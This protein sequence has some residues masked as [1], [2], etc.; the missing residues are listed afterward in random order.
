M[1]CVKAFGVGSVG[2]C[3]ITLAFTVVTVDVCPASW[4]CEVRRAAALRSPPEPVFTDEELVFQSPY[5]PTAET[6][7]RS[8]AGS[9]SCKPGVHEE[10]VQG[11]PKT[12]KKSLQAS[13]S[14]RDPAPSRLELSIDRSLEAAEERYLASSQPTLLVPDMEIPRV[15][16]VRGPGL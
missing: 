5:D 6:M 1:G 9:W 13:G 14:A 2:L 3:R 11:E 7:R 4:C 8:A 16:E 15:A 12:L 10:S